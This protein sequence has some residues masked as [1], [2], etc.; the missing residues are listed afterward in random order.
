M[1]I[2]AATSI[3]YG[4]YKCLFNK[5]KKLD[6]IIE[7]NIKTLYEL[8]N[9]PKDIRIHFRP[10][11]NVLLIGQYVSTTH[12]V[13]IDPRKGKIVELLAKVCHELV[14]AEQYHENRLTSDDKFF[15]W[16][17]EKHSYTLNYD[18]YCNYPWEIE[19]RDREYILYEAAFKESFLTK[20]N[21]K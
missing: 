21:I 20:K 12:T 2:T 6:K 9:M 14:H 8:I 19:A 16:H 11:R 7:S 10:I 5:V 1:I 3:R 18:I 15:Y 17:G 13:E 4:K